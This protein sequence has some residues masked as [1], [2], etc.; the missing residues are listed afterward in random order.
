MIIF[1][2]FCFCLISWTYFFNIW[3][4]VPFLLNDGDITKWY[5]HKNDSTNWMNTQILTIWRMMSHIFFFKNIWFTQSSIYKS[6]Q[7]SIQKTNI[8][9][10]RSILESILNTILYY[11]NIKKITFEAASSSGYAENGYNWNQYIHSDS[12]E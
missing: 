9:I 11:Y 8:K 5:Q 7:I 2:F 4:P 6:N 10:I 1:T 12:N 3:L